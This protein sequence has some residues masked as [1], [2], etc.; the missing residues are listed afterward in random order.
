MLKK[1]LRY[2]LKSVFRYWWIAALATL[3]LS[4]IGGFSLSIIETGKDIPPIIGVIIALSIFFAI[5]GIVAFPIFS[6]IMVYIRYYKNFFTDEGYL[7][8]TLPVKRSQL[9]NSKIITSVLIMVGTAIVIFIDILIMIAIFMGENFYNDFIMS[10]FQELHRIFSQMDILDWT[11]II[12]GIIEIIT[13][14]L[15]SAVYST[16]IVFGCIST[17][18][19]ITKKAKIIAAIGIY[20]ATNFVTSNLIY[21]TAIFGASFIGEKIVSLPAE[22][23]VPFEIIVLLAIIL[24]LALVCMLLYALNYFII[25]R[26]LNLA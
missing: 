4:V 10:L 11:Y 1:L 23:T 24:L 16:L 8:F 19:M 13:I 22:L 17:G 12:I 21:L 6:C 15:L 9:L 14:F 3:G 5:A 2:D 25:D 20:Y 7:T 18:A 26:K